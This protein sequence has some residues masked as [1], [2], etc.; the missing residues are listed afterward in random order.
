MLKQQQQ[1]QQNDKEENEKKEQTDNEPSLHL[2]KVHHIPIFWH[3][4]RTGGTTISTLLSKCHALVQ[5][6]SSFSSSSLYTREE[7]MALAARF[8]DPTL[9]TVRI[10]G[11]QYVNVDLDSLEG[12]QRAVDGGLIEKE[13]ANVVLVPDV[14]LGSLLFDGDT[15]DGGQQPQ[16]SQTN[17]TTTQQQ[18]QQDGEKK[19]YKGVMFAMFRHPIERA[20]SLFYH[21]QNVKD[22]IHH[23]PTLELASLEDW[24][25]SPF[26]ITD[27][28]VRTLVGKIDTPSTD[29][30]K[31]QTPLTATDLDVAKEILRRKC[32]VG[33]LEEK[34]ESM[35]RY[36]KFFGWRADVAKDSLLAI[37]NEET[38]NAI[39]AARWSQNIKDEECSDKL[40]HFN[41]M[42][43]NKHHP[44]IE[45][46]SVVY[47]LIEGKNR[48]DMQLYMYARQLFEEQYMQLGFDDDAI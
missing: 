43:K 36:D 46:G 42:N 11:Q 40:L 41:W 23:E 20:A 17:T 1:Q 45:E 4:P 47:N 13:L 5:A 28:M 22:S 35:K 26:Y 32:I 9:Y 30:F 12:V 33:L 29:I 6:T 38:A 15:G 19:E 10:H 25:N 48:Y 37:E 27:W 7:D 2:L 3:I 14:R 44:E 31:M 21:K 39:H 24:I 18:Q 34:S 16:L 8:R